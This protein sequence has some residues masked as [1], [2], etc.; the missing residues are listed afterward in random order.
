MS[1]CWGFRVSEE[2]YQNI[3]AGEL[4]V[5]TVRPA[6]DETAEDIGMAV[7]DEIFIHR[8]Q[9]VMLAPGRNIRVII[10]RIDGKQICFRLAEKGE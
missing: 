5:L 9:D 10:T 7:G 6:G 1:Q 8:P 2:Q 4:K 3:L